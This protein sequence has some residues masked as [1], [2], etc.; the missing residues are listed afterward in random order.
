[1][2][3]IKK[4]YQEIISLLEANREATV[5]DVIDSVIALASAKTGGGGGKATS[6]HRNEAG[7]VVAVHCYYHKTWLSPALI[8]FG[9]KASSATGLNSM[10]KS[11][12]SNWT[13][14]ERAFKNAKEDL[15]SQTAA[16]DVDPADLN[17]MLTDLE[18][19]R[20][21]ILPIDGDYQGFETLDECLADLDARGML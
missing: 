9:K 17:A 16:G 18:A 11:G 6:F 5:N 20:Q 3:T 13:K 15:L 4:A 7:D 8:E 10:C 21:A 14:Q 19:D 12:V 1:M 2:A